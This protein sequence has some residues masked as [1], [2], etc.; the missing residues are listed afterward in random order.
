VN[1]PLVRKPWYPFTTIEG[2]HVILG[3]SPLT[4]QPSPLLDLR[5]TS[6]ASPFGQTTQM[7]ARFVDQWRQ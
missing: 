7:G 2:V 1:K 4:N 6:H 3:R 5:S